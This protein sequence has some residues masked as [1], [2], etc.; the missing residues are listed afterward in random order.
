METCAHLG[1][2]GRLAALIWFAL[3]YIKLR[4]L[5]WALE[6]ELEALA[7]GNVHPLFE[8]GEERIDD[9]PQNQAVEDDGHLPMFRRIHEALDRRQAPSLSLSLGFTVRKG[10]VELS[11]VTP[12]GHI[13]RIESFDDFRCRQAF[14]PSD[15]DL[16]QLIG[17]LDLESVRCGN[18]FGSLA[19]PQEVT[20][21]D[22][23]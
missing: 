12:A 14:E 7:V 10:P 23:R 2:W 20:R 15:I 11:L 16:P 17:G 9:H 3:F 18:Q 21:E 22:A 4:G 5:A 13:R 6:L 8:E 19:G 1:P